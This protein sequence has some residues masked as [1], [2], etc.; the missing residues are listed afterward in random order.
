MPRG[1]W[2]QWSQQRKSRSIFGRTSSPFLHRLCGEE[3]DKKTQPHPGKKKTKPNLCLSVAKNKRAT[4][5]RNK[6]KAKVSL[7]QC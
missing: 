6:S 1:L 4:G 3:E 2:C 5:Q 7:R